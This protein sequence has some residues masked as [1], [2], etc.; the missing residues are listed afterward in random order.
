LT[1]ESHQHSSHSVDSWH[2]A[3]SSSGLLQFW[4]RVP[5]SRSRLI[6]LGVVGLFLLYEVLSKSFGAYLADANPEAA[7][8]LNP[9]NPTA[10]LNLA[11]DK[12]NS[13]DSFKLLDP[14]LSAPRNVGPGSSFAK[15]DVASEPPEL[16]AA[17]PGKSEP[18]VEVP[19]QSSLDGAALAQIQGWAERALLEDPINPRALRILGQI[20][21]HTSDEEHTERLMQA[22]VRR[23][24][25]ESVA[26]YWMMRKS[27]QDQDYKAALRYSDILLR[28]RP[29][30]L[31]PVT[32]MLGKIAE[33]PNGS[34][35]LNALLA[36]NP[37]W[38]QQ[39][40]S[41]FPNAITDARTPLAIL[42]SLKNTANPPTASDLRPYLDFLIQHGFYDLAYYTWLQFLPPE[43]LAK[44][45]NLYNGSFDT[46]P[47]GI[48]FDWVLTKGAG[49]TVQAAAKG[50]KPE[51][52]GLR[53]QF[54]PGRVDYHD[55]TQMIMLSPGSYHFH[56]KYKGDLVSERSLEWRVI[57]A[58]KDQNVIGRGVVAR[59]GTTTQ[60][61]DLDFSFTVP[62]AE[63]PAQYVK[64]VFDARSASEKFI[65]G[66]IWFDDFQIARE[67]TPEAEG[68]AVAPEAGQ[69]AV[70]PTA[71]EPAATADD[72]KSTLSPDAGE[73]TATPE[74]SQPAAK[75]AAGEPESATGAS[76]VT[77]P[78][79]EMTIK[80]E[81]YDQSAA[82]T[83]TPEASQAQPHQ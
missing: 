26:V 29:Q 53:L 47:S 30:A 62:E 17:L 12:L 75:P 40:L 37:P 32:P 72:S 52:R 25:L 10:L 22:A 43:Q 64:L 78:A 15:G 20:S 1:V 59:G 61:N 51:E 9:R 44:A 83:S 33:S 77:P 67:E 42:L 50:D 56:G 69:Q 4:A 80:P 34:E 5:S 73:P 6:I 24:Q 57:C 58:P 3:L 63:C 31:V 21:E 70:A 82:P 11:E 46:P 7:L 55:V 27:Y 76:I 81:I 39:F 49:V 68:S 41:Y 16:G 48:P 71:D 19:K 65:S 8:G 13:D 79:G 23:S 28:T 14:V 60:W 38:R 45:G 35:E 18:P 54:G 66:S 2:S 74:A 36:T